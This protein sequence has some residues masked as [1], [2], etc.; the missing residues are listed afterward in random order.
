MFAKIGDGP[1]ENTPT[2]PKRGGKTRKN[3][4]R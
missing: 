2:K 4:K 3:K 1:L